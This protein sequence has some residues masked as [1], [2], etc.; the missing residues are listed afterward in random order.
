GNLQ[1]I[2]GGGKRKVSEKR[3]VIVLFSEITD[4]FICI[5]IRRIEIRRKLIYRSSIFGVFCVRL[6]E[7]AERALVPE[8][9]AASAEK[10]ER[11]LKPA[12]MGAPR[13]MLAQVPFARHIGVIA[14]RL[15]Y[16]GNGKY[17]F[18]QISFVSRLHI[19]I[20]GMHG[21]HGAQSRVMVI[22]SGEEH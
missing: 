5:K 21:W 17:A 12:G 10:G 8:M 18:V 6:F 16:L 1:R 19:L 13:R 7:S 14:C 4:H 2:V 9:T 20:G 3:P 11:P 15:Q 22:A